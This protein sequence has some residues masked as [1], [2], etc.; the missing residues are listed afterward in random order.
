MEDAQGITPG[1]VEDSSSCVAV[2]AGHHI[3]A[4]RLADD[5]ADLRSTCELRKEVFYDAVPANQDI[6]GIY[7]SDSDCY[8]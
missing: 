6:Q 5:V 8:A 7:I 4:V 1:A 2:F 3:I